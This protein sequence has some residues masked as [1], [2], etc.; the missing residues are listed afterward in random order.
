MICSSCIL[1]IRCLLQHSSCNHRD[2]VSD[3]VTTYFKYFL[4]ASRHA[5]RTTFDRATHYLSPQLYGFIVE[6]LFVFQSYC[7]HQAMGTPQFHSFG[8]SRL[9][10]RMIPLETV[11]FRQPLISFRRFCVHLMCQKF[12]YQIKYPKSGPGCSKLTTSLV[13]VS[14]KFQMLIPEICQY[15][16]LKKCE[17]LL[18]CKSFSH[19]FNKKYQCIW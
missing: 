13:N 3:P 8:L 15:F 10:Q 17:K 16:L 7:N 5:E 2:P 1:A 12:W 19:F 4:D 14:L 11:P 9:H 6:K 18:Q